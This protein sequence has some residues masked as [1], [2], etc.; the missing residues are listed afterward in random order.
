MKHGSPYAHC[1][2]FI[3]LSKSHIVEFA[4]LSRSFMHATL[5]NCEELGYGAHLVV[6]NP[7]LDISV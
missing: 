5:K 6:S 2:K 1:T 7:L 4:M 3:P